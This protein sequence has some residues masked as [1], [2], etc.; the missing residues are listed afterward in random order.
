M[1]WLR[2]AFVVGCGLGLVES[3]ASA[4]LGITSPWGN[5]ATIIAVGKLTGIG[6]AQVRYVVMKNLQ[7]GSV[8]LNQCAIFSVPYQ[9]YTS[10]PGVMDTRLTDSVAI[11]G[12]G[13]RDLISVNRGGSFNCNGS[14]FQSV[15]EDDG[16]FEAFL[17]GYYVSVFAG[18]GNDYIASSAPYPCVVYGGVGDDEILGTDERSF[19]Y[20]ESDGDRITLW[21]PYVFTSRIASGGEGND[22]LESRNNP[23]TP[24][25]YLFCHGGDDTRSTA[26]SASSQLPLLPNITCEHSSNV[27]CANLWFGMACS[28]GS[29]CE[30]GSC[31]A[32]GKCTMPTQ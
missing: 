26:G 21:N 10:S 2:L 30:S 11:Y 15:T 22:C 4:T 9:W 20:G 27:V 5:D 3:S 8:D 19:A 13:G 29:D 28:V 7:P 32:Q 6:V 1:K 14:S 18:N 17:N 12:G 23:G 16:Y 25:S 31:D 24:P